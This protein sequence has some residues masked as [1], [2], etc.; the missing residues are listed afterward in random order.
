MSRI[1]D[2][3]QRANLERGSSPESNSPEFIESFT[4]PGEIERPAVQE[5]VLFDLITRHLWNPS[6]DA[7]PTLGDRSESMEQFRGLRTQVYQFRDQAPLKTI[8][9]SSGSPAE[10]K[11]FVAVNLAISL[12]RNK[13]NTVLLI[14]ADL[15]KPTLH[16]ILGTPYL[17][18]L[19]EY[20]AGSA[21][22]REILQRN[23]HF[24]NNGEEQSWQIPDLTFIP[25]GEGGD[26]SSE[27]V[28]NHRFEELITLLSPLFDWII[29]DSP[30]VLA[31][32]DAID[33][34]R[35]A[36]AVLL[37]ARA[38]Q[39]PYDVAQRAQSAFANSRLLGFVLN[40]VKEAP[41]GGSYYFY[42]KREAGSVSHGSKE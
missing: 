32:A 22:A 17:P 33:L 35:G 20:L 25:S 6:L 4:V 11:T 18:G 42:G 31:V 27:L 1:Y 16:K 21:Q 13:N 3:L 2:A 41:H 23:Q 14:D 39:T 8:L 40:A 38:A 36:D 28:A 29:V 34:A 12:A 5:D 10:G 30:P 15:R 24:R 9:V 37:V 26:H 7:L 19:A